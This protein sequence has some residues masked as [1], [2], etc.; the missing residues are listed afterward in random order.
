MNS[1]AVPA[2]RG[3]R[4][5]GLSIL[6]I[7][8]LAALIV[9]LVFG[10][11]AQAPL[12]VDP[13]PVVLWGLPAAKLTSNLGAAAMLGS[14]VLALF[15]LR[16]GSRPFDLAVDVASIGAAVF[17]I[18][19]GLTAF[20]TFMAAFN[21]KLSSGQAFGEQFG[22]FLLEIPLGQA[23][24]IATLMGAVV[25]VMAFAWRNWT[26]TLFTAVLAA[27]SLIPMATQGHNGDLSGHTL[28]V[29]AILLHTVGAAVW[30]GGL[31][32]LVLLRPATATR[33]SAKK[34]ERDAVDLGA[35]VSRYSSLALA[36]FT[37]VAV[38]GIARG[39]VA[40]GD[41]AALWSPYGLIMIAKAVLLVGLGL[42]GFW[43]RLR[44][45]PISTVRAQR[46]HSG[47]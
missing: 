8:A 35:L 12:L 44:L 28:A 2:P 30:L 5:A 15:A 31:M 1:P 45:I 17:T 20:L 43:Y 10:G 9:A 29:N 38:S 27:A 22:S 33:T 40:L 3:Y 36:A 39:A 37:V 24:L 13:G 42:F 11:G 19:S 18:S 47:R 21:P 16:S 4:I 14:L 26:G 23:W 32:L 46:A 41:W 6:V 7:A 34:R 25:T